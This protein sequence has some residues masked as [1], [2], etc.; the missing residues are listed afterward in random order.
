MRAR[1]FSIIEAAVAA[2]VLALGLLAI[3]GSERA[4]ARLDLL[5]RRTA[6]ATEAAAGRL[7]LL[8]ARACLA[9]AAGHLPGVIDQQWSVAAGGSLRAASVTV[10]F[11]HDARPRT[12]RYDVLWLCP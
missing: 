3:I 10:S 1:G 5:G 2:A 8:E 4:M 9:P 11:Q 7:A 12:S 6:E